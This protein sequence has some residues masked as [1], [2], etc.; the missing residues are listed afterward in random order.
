[1]MDRTGW[2]ERSGSMSSMGKGVSVPGWSVST[3]TWLVVWLVVWS[4]LSRAWLA[5]SMMSSMS[6]LD[7]SMPPVRVVRRIF[8]RARL[9]GVD[10]SSLVGSVVGSS[11]ASWFHQLAGS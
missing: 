1:M 9:L 2:S 3:R 6:T 10:S 8:G 5:S 4:V 7:R 11:S